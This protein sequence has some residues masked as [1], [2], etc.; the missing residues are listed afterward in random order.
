MLSD[1]LILISTTISAL[2]FFTEKMIPYEFEPY[3]ADCQND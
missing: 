2:T 1:I 3:D